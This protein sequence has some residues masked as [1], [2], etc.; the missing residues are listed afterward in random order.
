V[1]FAG[2]VC[3]DLHAVGET[4]TGDLTDS[5]VRLTWCFG[6]DTSADPALERRTE[7]GRAVLE[8]VE[9]TGEGNGLS[10]PDFLLTSLSY[11]LPYRGHVQ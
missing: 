10:T 11:E 6:G 1:T 4:D 8:R 3:G 9:A 5:G 2:D 7:E